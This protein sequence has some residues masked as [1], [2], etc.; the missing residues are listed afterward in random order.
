MEDEM[1]NNQDET[2]MPEGGEASEETPVSEEMPMGEAPEAPAEE[3]AAE[4]GE[5]ET[6]EE[7]GEESEEESEEEAAA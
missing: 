7:G 4:G 3:E 1:N 2:T 5:E 6:P